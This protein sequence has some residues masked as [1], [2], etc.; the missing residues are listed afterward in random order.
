MNEA[1]AINAIRDSHPCQCAVE[2]YLPD[3]EASS[4]RHASG[5]ISRSKDFSDA[6]AFVPSLPG[7]SAS[8]R[9]RND[10]ADGWTRL[11]PGL[12]A[13]HDLL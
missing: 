3:V 9:R 7:T 11:L 10:Y 5:K 6:L 1:P 2:S 4:Q 13:D 8:G 12:S